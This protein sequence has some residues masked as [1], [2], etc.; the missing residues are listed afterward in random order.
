[1]W[2]LEMGTQELVCYPWKTCDV[3][4]QGHSAITSDPRDS[5]NSFVT[6]DGR[7]SISSVSP[8]SFSA[9]R[10][11]KAGSRAD[12]YSCLGRRRRCTGVLDSCG[13][14]VVDYLFTRCVSRGAITR[15]G[16]PIRIANS[17][18][19]LL[20]KHDV[21]YYLSCQAYSGRHEKIEVSWN[22]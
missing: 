21:W 16:V 8:G 10:R 14:Y 12:V 11:I 13:Y 9:S 17:Q 20:K 1:M 22:Y 4:G 18:S 15:S 19:F 7:A 3:A 6:I 2:M 5:T